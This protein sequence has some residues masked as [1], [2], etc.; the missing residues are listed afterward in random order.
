MI[1][2]AIVR[3]RLRPVAALGHEFVELRLV[4]GVAKPLQEVHEFL[5]LFLEPAQRFGPIFVESGIAAA[6]AAQSD[7]FLLTSTRGNRPRRWDDF[8]LFLKDMGRMPDSGWWL[9]RRNPRNM[10]SRWN[11][12]WGLPNRRSKK[13]GRLLAHSQIV[14]V[15]QFVV[16]AS[17][18][19]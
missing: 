5:L 9:Q 14:V 1:R 11:C 19:E 13:V 3:R 16:T 15:R 7:L 8:R 12:Y 6:I 4:L 18:D 2:R 17:A 10:F